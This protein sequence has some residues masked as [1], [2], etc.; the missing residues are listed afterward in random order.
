MNY[1]SNR[2]VYVETGHSRSEWSHDI[3]IYI[4]DRKVAQEYADEIKKLTGIPPEVQVEIGGNQTHKD[5]FDRVIHGQTEVCVTFPFKV[6]QRMADAYDI[7]MTFDNKTGE[8]TE[9]NLGVSVQTERT[10][11]ENLLMVIEIINE[12]KKLKGVKEF[13][14]ILERID[15]ETKTDCFWI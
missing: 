13:K 11:P 14:E 1:I 7:G 15:T 5:V 10:A 8:I 9:V 12:L 2:G 6:S 4:I 3:T